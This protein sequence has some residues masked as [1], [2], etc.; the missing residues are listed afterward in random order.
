MVQFDVFEKCFQ[1]LKITYNYHHS[2]WT[3]RNR[4]AS[5]QKNQTEIIIVWHRFLPIDY[6]ESEMLLYIIAALILQVLNPHLGWFNG[7]IT[8]FQ[9]CHVK[10][11]VIMSEIQSLYHLI[12]EILNIRI[13]YYP[14]TSFFLIIWRDHNWNERKKMLQSKSWHDPVI[15]IFHPSPLC[16]PHEK[17][18]LIISFYV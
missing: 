2:F 9:T 11:D 10:R 5:Q 1:L 3:L 4:K 17:L 16:A 12:F 13:T 6:S 18:I 7:T 14:Q 15:I 8:Y